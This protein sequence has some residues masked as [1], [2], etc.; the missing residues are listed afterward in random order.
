MDVAVGPPRVLPPTPPPPPL[1]PPRKFAIKALTLGPLPLPPLPL[2]LL[3][4]LLAPDDAED[5]DVV[6]GAD[7]ALVSIGRVTL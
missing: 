2:P 6:V 5:V 3:L 1:L 4:L 7:G